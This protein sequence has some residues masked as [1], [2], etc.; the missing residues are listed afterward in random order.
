MA[1]RR[2]LILRSILL[3]TVSYMAVQCAL[4]LAIGPRG[5][6]LESPYAWFFGAVIVFH[7][8]IFA[9]VSWRRSDFLL[10]E[11]GEPL[12]RVNLATHLTLFRLSCA[13]TILFLA[14]AVAR[15]D[16]GGIALVV[17]VAVAFLSDL[18]DG[19]VARRLHQLTRIGS[20]LD[21]STDYAVLVV[22]SVSFV[23]L[24]ITPL[25]YFAALMFRL[26]GFAVAMLLLTLRRG[27]LNAETT[28]MGK[29][30]VFSAMTTFAFE[31]AQHVD[32]GGVGNETVVFWVEIASAL[33]LFVSVIDKGF[34]V[35]RAFR[36]TNQQQ[37]RD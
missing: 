18:L 20:Y 10:L 27:G 26:L 24:G 34:Y 37:S 13:P 32:L 21:S 23:V 25:W 15:G 17:L 8:A 36:T 6:A 22:L 28:L 33:I 30:A 1:V 29:A 9:I 31:I 4:W 3:S 16:T 14:I 5:L 11:S 12:S 7:A 35:G 2:N 19:Q